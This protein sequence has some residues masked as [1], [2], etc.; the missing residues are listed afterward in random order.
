ML[1]QLLTLGLVVGLYHLYFRHVGDGGPGFIFPRNPFNYWEEHLR[2]LWIYHSILMVLLV[3]ATFIDFDWMIIPDSIT[4]TGMLLALVLGTF[5]YVELHPVLLFHPNP[6]FS[7]GLIGAN[8]F[9]DQFGWSTTPVWLESARQAF[10]EHWKHHWNAWL[11]FL[12]GIVG[13]IVGGGTV[14]VV[15]AVCSFI[16]RV[17][18]IGFGDVTLMAMVGAFVGWQT[19]VM[20]FFL[21]P[22]SAVLVGVFA[23]FVSGRR[24]IPYGPHLSIASAGCVLGWPTIWQQTAEIFEH[25]GIVL[26]MAGI[27][28][29]VLVAVA[30]MIQAVKML[31]FGMGAA[32][33]ER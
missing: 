11:G 33:N 15:R 7:S 25:G 30:S 22:I 4:V 8:F 28:V 23:Y 10:N 31:I 16:F 13:L 21:A 9:A 32:A 14:W 17:E 24:A 29:V 6:R 27:M 12:T 2:A 19:A 18:A 20:A 5:W 26:F 1:V 3:A